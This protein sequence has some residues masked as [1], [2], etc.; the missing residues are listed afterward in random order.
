M[1]LLSN[2]RS[3]HHGVLDALLVLAFAVAE[4]AAR[5][6]RHGA[7]QDD[8]RRT[9]HHCDGRVSV[10]AEGDVEAGHL[11][12]VLGADQAEGAV[13]LAAAR[14]LPAHL[15]RAG[16]GRIDRNI[17]RPPGFDFIELPG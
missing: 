6:A 7:T 15:A 10:V 8:A 16:V 9:L 3:K 4:A 1:V 2:M 5:T 14:Q 11:P 12:R 13:A 17:R